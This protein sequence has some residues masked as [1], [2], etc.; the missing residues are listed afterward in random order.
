MRSGRTLSKGLK[1]CLGS[2]TTLLVYFFFS[3]G[4]SSSILQGDYSSFSYFLRGVKGDSILV[5]KE[6]KKIW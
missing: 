2:K 4:F 3:L 5:S 1:S 6:V